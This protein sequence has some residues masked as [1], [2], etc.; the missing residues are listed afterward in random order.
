MVYDQSL[1]VGLAVGIPCFV[2][3]LGGSVLYLRRR[4]SDRREDALSADVE[5]RDSNS[6]TEFHEALHQ[7]YAPGAPATPGASP[8]KPPLHVSAHLASTNTFSDQTKPA[9]RTPLAYDFY[10]RFIPIL[11]DGELQPPQVPSDGRSVHS[12]HSTPSADPLRSLDNL[13]KQL[14]AP[15]FA[16][17]PPAAALRQPAPVMLDPATAALLLDSVH[18]TMYDRMGINDHYV[19]DRAVYDGDEPP[20]QRHAYHELL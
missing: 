8:E 18:N 20:R 10:D 14:Q 2:V 4:R 6:Y 9:G 15:F 11:G 5:M 13:A 7:P 3:L 12:G 19:T 17:L 16:K 1:A